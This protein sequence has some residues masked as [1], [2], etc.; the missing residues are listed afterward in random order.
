MLCDFLKE[1]AQ[2]EKNPNRLLSHSLS[3]SLSWRFGS[4]H[5]GFSFHMHFVL[6]I[7]CACKRFA[8]QTNGQVSERVKSFSLKVR[9]RMWMRT[10]KRRAKKTHLLREARLTWKNSSRNIWIE[11]CV[12]GCECECDVLNSTLFCSRQKLQLVRVALKTTCR[13]PCSQL[14]TAPPVG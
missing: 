2:R 12:N 3:L 7:L 6:F 9:E 5:R 11:M 10:R 13:A 14:F 1:R 8:I 4:R